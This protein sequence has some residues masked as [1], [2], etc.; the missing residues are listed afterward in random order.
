MRS[1]SLVSARSRALPRPLKV[2]TSLFAAFCIPEDESLALASLALSGPCRS[3]SRCSP[4]RCQHVDG[5]NSE[6][7]QTASPYT[8]VPCTPLMHLNTHIE[9][10]HTR[11]TWNTYIQQKHALCHLARAAISDDK[12]SERVC[13]HAGAAHVYS[14][15]HLSEGLR[16]QITHEHRSGRHVC[17]DVVF[18][19]FWRG[20]WKN[21]CRA[22]HVCVCVCVCVCVRAHMYAWTHTRTH[23]HAHAYEHAR[24]FLFGV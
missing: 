2:G 4:E 21:L 14:H 22:L 24:G 1:R 8:S 18:S 19:A 5:S 9:G 10:I 15:L 11:Y 3:I 6:R 23:A 12:R 13:M 7:S 20:N 16:R 17:L